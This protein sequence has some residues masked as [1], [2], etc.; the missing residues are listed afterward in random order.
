[1]KTFT[2]GSIAWGWATAFALGLVMQVAISDAAAQDRPID[3]GA[4]QSLEQLTG[5]TGLP[6]QITGFG[7]SGYSP[8]RAHQRQHVPGQQVRHFSVPRTVGELL[9]VRP[10]NHTARGAP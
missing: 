7:T 1:M 9:D 8:R 10:A 5:E 6:L 2:L 3:L 4:G